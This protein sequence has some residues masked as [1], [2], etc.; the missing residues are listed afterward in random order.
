[1]S[2]I[3][4]NM[5]INQNFDLSFNLSECAIIMSAWKSVPEFMLLCNSKYVSV[6]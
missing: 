5:S 2:D 6:P 4:K 3:N 1:M